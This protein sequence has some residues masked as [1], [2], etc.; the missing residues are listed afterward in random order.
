MNN[1]T[2]GPGQSCNA[3]SIGIGFEATLVANPTTV[4]TA[5]PPP[6]NPCGD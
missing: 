1:G 2:K 6:P 5:S 3:I 4:Q